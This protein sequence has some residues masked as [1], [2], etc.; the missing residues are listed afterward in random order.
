MD[1]KDRWKNI[2]V[3]RNNNTNNLTN[4]DEISSTSMNTSDSNPYF[5]DRPT[6]RYHKPRKR[7]RFSYFLVALVAA[8]IGG[9]ISAYIAPVY[10]YGKILPIPEIYKQNISQG[11]Q[12]NI[13][14]NDNITNVTAVAEKTMKSV[15]GITTVET[16][17]DFFRGPMQMQGVGSGVIVDSDGYILTNSHV[18]GDGKADKITVQFEDGTKKEAKVLWYETALD[19][20]VI[21][22]EAINLPVAEFGDSDDIKV[23]ELAI[24]IGNPLGLQFQRTVTSGIISGL[25]R[26]IKDQNID[27]QDLIQTD[28]S[29]NPG[30]SGGPLLNAKG[31][32]IGINTAKITSAEGLGFSIPINVAKPIVSEVIEKGTIKTVYIGISA[33]DVDKYQKALNIDLS[34]DTGVI[35]IETVAGSPANRAGIRP[36]DIVLKIDGNDV[37]DM[38]NLRKILYKYKSG[39]KAKV[40]LLRDGEEKIINIVF[41]DKPDNY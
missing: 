38:N 2:S 24:A 32:V 13:T 25:N 20:A 33:Y 37:V 26:T 16:K 11:Q 35:V 36:G 8:L 15:V 14:P 7:S 27:M 9:L 19:L 31:E 1:D 22:V 17:V 40:T 12:I 10:L 18:I 21:K 39:D 6:V 5:I 4:R 34:V 23:G 28:A 41:K 29:I 30:N 3:D